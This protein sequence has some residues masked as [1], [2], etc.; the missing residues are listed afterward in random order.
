MNSRLSVRVLLGL[1]LACLGAASVV[2]VSHGHD[3]LPDDRIAL[4]YYK[5]IQYDAHLIERAAG[6]ARLLFVVMERGSNERAEILAG[7]MRE[8]GRIAREREPSALEI[9]ATVFDLDSPQLEDALRTSHAVFL[10]SEEDVHAKEKLVRLE[11]LSI[12]WQLP[13]LSDDR[14]LLETCA[15][16]SVDPVTEDGKS[17]PRMSIHL[18]RARAQGSRFNAKFLQLCDV[19]GR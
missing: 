13:I 4:I 5:A 1:L 19:T 11:A 7:F 8:A 14:A 6:E 15:T 16:V 17:R 3:R 9:H 18:D 12:R 2:S 10:V